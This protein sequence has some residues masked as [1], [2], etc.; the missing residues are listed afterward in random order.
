MDEEI[1][2]ELQEE[3]QNTS[4]SVDDTTSSQNDS[5]S[6]TL[7]CEG[8]FTTFQSNSEFVVLCGT[9]TL[10]TFAKQS[11]SKQLDGVDNDSH[12]D[13]V[14][15]AASV[16]AALTLQ[17]DSA[18][19]ILDDT[20][21]SNKKADSGDVNHVDK[22]ESASSSNTLPAN[23]NTKLY[24]IGDYKVIESPDLFESNH[25]HY[26]NP[27]FTSSELKSGAKEAP[28][29]ISSRPSRAASQT[30][31]PKRTSTK[32]LNQDIGTVA[33]KKRATKATVLIDDDVDDE[34]VTYQPPKK[35]KVI[36]LSISNIHFSSICPL[37]V[38]ETF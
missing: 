18:P 19:T 11:S 28:L 7:E 16:T 12:H 15:N 20:S 26:S 37:I 34:E 13:A 32:R 2:N 9:C 25:P 14:I 6:F 4:T 10:E 21:D 30:T 31:S 36:A 8:C 17:N 35:Q 3:I 38:S 33:K 1:M 23:T 27:M 29:P 5:K 22:N 24:D